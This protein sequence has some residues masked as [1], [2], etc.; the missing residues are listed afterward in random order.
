MPNRCTNDI[1]V[2]VQPPKSLQAFQALTE[3][4]GSSSSNV[5]TAQHASNYFET[6]DTDPHTIERTRMLEML[7]ERKEDVLNE[8]ENIVNERM[9][10]RMQKS[11]MF[12]MAIKS[13]LAI[14]PKFV[15]HSLEKRLLVPGSNLLADYVSKWSFENQTQNP[16][17]SLQAFF[18]QNIDSF[19]EDV[20][21]ILKNVANKSSVPGVKKLYE[22]KWVQ[23]MVG[24]EIRK[25][26]PLL[27]QLITKFSMPLDQPT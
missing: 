5:K 3:S 4:P 24:E 12:R 14:K 26:I 18:E 6:T 8:C 17:I 22:M 19:I 2:S 9:H 20:R 25:G 1:R 11:F 13:I 16:P 10:K 21:A 7:I 15:R 27:V 23:K